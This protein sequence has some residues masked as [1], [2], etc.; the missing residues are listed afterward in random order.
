MKKVII[1]I[2]NGA[3]TCGKTTLQTILHNK[4]NDICN[5]YIRS[6]VDVMYDVYRKLGWNGI[7]DDTFRSDIHTLKEMYIRNCD[8]P[9]RDIMT[10]AMNELVSESKNNAI[11]FYDIREADEINKLVGIIKPLNV[12]GL[13]CKTILVRRETAESF[14]HGNY[15]DDNVLADGVNYDI[16]VEN[17]G[18]MSQL[19]CKADSIISKILEV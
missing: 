12:I 16:V 5:V 15:A 6:S 2:M 7:K 3:A 8:G 1:V 10:M 19:E 9:T 14:K 18:S 17:N 4:V 11:I 13:Y